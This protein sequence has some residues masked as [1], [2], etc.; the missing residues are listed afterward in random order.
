MTNEVAHIF[1]KG[2]QVFGISHSFQPH[3]L[4][5][6]AEFVLWKLKNDWDDYNELYHA[7]RY[8]ENIKSDESLQIDTHLIIVG[9]ELKGVVFIISG[10]VRRLETKYA[11]EKEENALVLKYFHILDRGRGTGQFWLQEVIFP[12][13]RNQGFERVYLNSS[14]PQSF[15]FYRKF[16]THIGDY[17]QESDNGLFV[18]KGSSFEI[19]L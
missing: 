9:K 3:Y 7:A 10:K 4:L 16:G 15:N 17:T 19:L 8:F 13:Y 5:P 12:Y 11:I 6:V 14:H 2:D 1:T 18:R